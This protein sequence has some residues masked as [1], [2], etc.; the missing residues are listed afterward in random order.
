MISIK[1]GPNKWDL[2]AALADR[3]KGRFIKLTLE[4]RGLKCEEEYWV[5]GISIEDGS[6][7][8]WNLNLSSKGCAGAHRAYYS[9][10]SRS[11]TFIK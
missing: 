3:N 8:S 5:D 6:G 2:F 7:E 9:S 11:G 10:A 1:N 4:E